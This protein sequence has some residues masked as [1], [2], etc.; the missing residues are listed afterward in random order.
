MNL[1][2]AT[3]LYN[4]M[5]HVIIFLV[6]VVFLFHNY[7]HLNVSIFIMFTVVKPINHSENGSTRKHAIGEKR[8]GRGI[9]ATF[10]KPF[11]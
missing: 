11:S 7:F 2:S 3:P 10:R 6:L 8:E 1:L 9:S 4:M 5:F